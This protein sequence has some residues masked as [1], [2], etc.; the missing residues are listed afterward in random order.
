M[1]ARAP[2][3][4]EQLRPPAEADQLRPVRQ[5]VGVIERLLRLLFP[6]PLSLD[7]ITVENVINRYPLTG[8]GAPALA[9]ID[10]SQRIVRARGDYGQVGLCEFHIGLIFLYWDDCRA[11]ANQ[12]ALARQ[13]WSLV[14]DAPAMCLAHYAQGLGLYHSYHNEA[15]M[16]QFG[17]AERLLGRPAIGAQAQR[18]A[19]LAEEMRPLLVIAQE[20]LR[21]SLWPREHQPA[22]ALKAGYLTVPETQQAQQSDEQPAAARPAASRQSVA[23]P[24]SRLGMRREPETPVERPEWAKRVPPPFSQ[25]PES[26]SQS[27]RGPVPGHVTTDDRFGWYVIADKRGEFLPSMESGTWLLADREVDD[28][29][30]SG[31]EYV[32]IGSSRADLGSIIV[33]SVSHT[34]AVPYCYL[35]YRVTGEP[36]SE[37]AQLYL[38]ETDEPLPHEDVFVLAVVE[39]F[40]QGADGHTSKAT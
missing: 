6:E 19:K 15:A 40:W 2:N 21:E 23:Q 14:S 25:L 10:Q 33:Q 1:V 16:L 11:A 5:A 13:P 29:P 28:H 7:V 9:A 18:F 26:L 31:R 4:S 3:T 35:G 36:T 30:S 22:E 8:L 34:S 37:P 38:D 20:T 17:R 12:F 24:E 27:M 39:G 32:V